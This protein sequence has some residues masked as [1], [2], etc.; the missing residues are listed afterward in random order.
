MT[1]GTEAVSSE[2]FEKILRSRRPYTIAG[3]GFVGLAVLLWLMLFKPTFGLG[4]GE[5]AAGQCPHQAAPVVQICAVDDQTFVTKTVSAPAA[6]PFQIRFVNQDAGV[7][8][9]VSIYTDDSATESLFIGDL[10]LGIGTGRYDVPALDAGSYYFRC[11]IHPVMDGT[12]EV[13]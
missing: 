7:Q 3:V 13:G 11:D 6:E 1:E 8:H 9:N 2:Q 5:A 12:L 10:I 4:G